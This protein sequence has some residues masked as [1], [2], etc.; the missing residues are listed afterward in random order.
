MNGRIIKTFNTKSIEHKIPIIFPDAQHRIMLR[1]PDRSPPQIQARLI[2]FGLDNRLRSITEGRNSQRTSD[3][4]NQEN[5]R[6][7]NSH[8]PP[9]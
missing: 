7:N 1:D 6:D 8:P 3:N 9:A 4:E 2:L 5:G